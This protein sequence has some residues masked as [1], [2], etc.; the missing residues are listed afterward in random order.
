MG[1]YYTPVFTDTLTGKIQKLDLGTLHDYPG[2]KLMEH[3]Y[4]L[5]DMIQTV[6]HIIYRNPVRLAWIGDYA[7]EILQERFPDEEVTMQCI[8]DDDTSMFDKMQTYNILKLYTKYN[9]NMKFDYHGK[10][11]VNHTAKVA[12]NFDDYMTLSQKHL[13]ENERNGWEISPIS[14][15]T[16]VGNGQGGG[17][18]PECGANYDMVGEWA[19]CKVSIEDEL[20]AGYTADTTTY[21]AETD[22]L[23]DKEESNE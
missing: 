2:A 10:W 14:L 19:F 6:A 22:I 7:R 17:D 8:T 16:A 20:P 15:L 23:T 11:F 4:M 1:Q 21:F 5:N 13:P 12:I 18:Y 9:D 3:S